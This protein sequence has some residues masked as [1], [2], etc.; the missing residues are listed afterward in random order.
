MTYS[1]LTPVAQM[2]F[3]EIRSHFEVNTVC[4]LV[5]FQAT[6]PLLEASK[7]KMFAVPDR[8]SGPNDRP[9]LDSRRGPGCVSIAR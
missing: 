9:V 6:V 4:T 8:H 3:A 2:P 1:G 5:L 7:H